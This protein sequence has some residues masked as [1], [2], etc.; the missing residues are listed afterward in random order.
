MK[1]RLRPSRA[2]CCR[3]KKIRNQNSIQVK[4]R[5]PH[6]WRAEKK[7]CGRCRSV[8]I[9]QVNYNVGRGGV[10]PPGVPRLLFR[11][12]VASPKWLRLYSAYRRSENITKLCIYDL[13]CGTA[14][15]RI[16]YEG[17]N[18]ISINDGRDGVACDGPRVD[19]EMWQTVFL[20]REFDIGRA[21]PRFLGKELFGRVV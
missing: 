18:E 13:K 6:G 16:Y 5:G 10:E 21:A 2:A 3:C 14:V 11:F 20:L 12:A 19:V 17:M 1:N 7:C 15:P 8:I 4:A 9:Y